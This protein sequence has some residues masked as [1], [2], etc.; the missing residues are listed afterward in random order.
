MVCSVTQ[1]KTGHRWDDNI[2]MNIK[3]TE[4]EGVDSV[5]LDE[6]GGQYRAVVNMAMNLRAL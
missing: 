4:G 1:R 3:E 5:Y 6:K 2:K